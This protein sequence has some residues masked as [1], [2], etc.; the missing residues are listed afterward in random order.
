MIHYCCG[1]IFGEIFVTDGCVTG[2]LEGLCSHQLRTMLSTVVKCFK[3]LSRSMTV[4]NLPSIVTAA[5]AK[6]ANAWEKVTELR[7]KPNVRGGT[8]SPPDY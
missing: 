6:Q 3:L 4:L 7:G 1:P 5:M 2:V 8:K